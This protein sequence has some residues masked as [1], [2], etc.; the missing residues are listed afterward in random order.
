MKNI[1][2]LLFLLF[3]F[4]LSG[5]DLLTSRK[6]S[7]KTYIFKISNQE[8]EE[9]YKG[10]RTAFEI[11]EKYYHTLVDSFFTDSTYKKQ[12]PYGHYLDAHTSGNELITNIFTVSPFEVFVLN[13]QTDLM[14]QVRD[15][16]GNY[17]ENAEVELDSRAIKFNQETQSYRIGKSNQDGW[18]KVEMDG[19]IIFQQLNKQYKNSRAK[20]IYSK[21][22]YSRPIRWIWRPVRF[23]VGLPIDGV[24]SIIKGRTVG[25]IYRAK[26][27]PR[28]T[29]DLAIDAYEK[30]ACIFDDDYCNGNKNKYEDIYFATN[31]PKYFLK[32]TVFFK[33]FIVKSR[34]EKPIDKILEVSIGNSS[35]NEIKL[36]KIQP[37]YDGAYS[38]DFVLSDSLKLQLDRSYPIYLKDKKRNTIAYTYIKVEDYELGKTEF[39]FRVADNQQFA[40]DTFKIFAKGTDENDLQLPDAKIELTLLT[41]SISEYFPTQIFIPD[42]LWNHSQALKADGE[43]EIVL[44]DS[45][46]PNAEFTY[47]IIAEMRTSDNERI[48]KKETISYFQSKQE[49]ELELVGD[50][51]K[52]DYFKN[53]EV[54]QIAGTVEIFDGFSNS[55]RKQNV[56]FPAILPLNHYAS[57]LLVVAE[58]GFQQW[59]DLGN[60]SS[61]LQCFANRTADTVNIQVQNPH[62][63]PFVYQIYKQSN[64]IEKGNGL[65]LNWKEATSSKKNYYV[66]IQYLWAGKVKELN[67]EVGLKDKQLKISVEQPSLVVPGQ[68]VEL[69]VSVKDHKGKPVEDVDLLAYSLTSKFDYSAPNLPYLGKSRKAR[70]AFNKFS[71]DKKYREMD[72]RN[73]ELNYSK[74]NPLANLDSLEYYQLTY[75]KNNYYQVNFPSPDSLTQFAPFVVKGGEIQSIHSIEVDNLPIYFRWTISKNQPFSFLVDS[76]FHQVKLRT[77]THE[78][79]LDSVYFGVGE[80]QI[81]SV[82]VE[83]EAFSEKGKQLTKFITPEKY[84]QKTGFKS[85]LR[86]RLIYSQGRKSYPTDSENKKWNLYTAGYRNPHYSHFSAI[87]QGNRFFP[88]TGYS[89]LIGPLVRD[90]VH[91]SLLDSF[92]TSFVHE[93]NFQYEFYP[94]ILKMRTLNDDSFSYSLN[95]QKWSGSFSDLALTEN[96]F[97]E[98]WE[99]Y[100]LRMRRSSRFFSNP[101]YTKAGFGSLKIKYLKENVV[102]PLNIVMMKLDDADFLRVYN[103]VSTTFNQL[104][105]GNYKLIFLL[106]DN[107]YYSKDSIKIGV[108]GKNF[109]TISAPDSLSETPLGTEMLEMINLYLKTSETWS[110]GDLSNENLKRNLQIAYFAEN[111]NFN[112]DSP[113]ITGTVKD[114]TGEGLPGTTITIK[115]T[116]YGTVSDMDGNYSIR[117]NYGDILRFSFAGM[118]PTE[119]LIISQREIDVVLSSSAM[120]EEVVVVSYGMRKTGSVDRSISSMHLEEMRE[121]SIINSL[122]GKISGIE[123]EDGSLSFG[124]SPKILIRGNSTI[125]GEN[126][127]LYVIDGV[128]Y[129]GDLTQIRIAGKEVSP[130]MI[131]SMQVL[132]GAAAT[133]LYGA[134]G[135]NG[136]IL[137]TSKGNILRTE[138]ARI[139]G[140]EN[141]I[142]KDIEQAS[143]GSS[144][145]SNFSDYAFWK[146]NLRTNSEG[147]AQFKVKFPDDITK[148]ETFVLGVNGNRQ[149]GQAQGEIKSFKPL[150]AQLALPRFLLVGD[151]AFAIGKTLN[152]SADSVEVKQTFAVNDKNIWQ[153]NVRLERSVID[154]LLLT[155]STT[156]SLS[157]KYTME[158]VATNGKGYLDGELRKIPV[159]PVGFERA[160]GD[161]FTLDSDTSFTIQPETKTKKL[162][163]RAETDQLEVALAEVARLRKYKYYCNEQLASK[164]KGLLVEQRIAQFLGKEKDRK[165]EIEKI[166]EKLEK[167]QKTNGTWGWWENSSSSYWISTHVVQAFLQAEIAGFPTKMNKQALIDGLVWQLE[168]RSGYDKLHKLQILEMLDAKVDYKKHLA[169]LDTT[170]TGMLQKYQIL[171]LKQKLKLPYQTDSLKAEMRSTL[172]GNLYWSEREDDFKYYWNVYDNPVFTT[173]QAYKVLRNDSVDSGTLTKIRQ[174][175][176]ENRTNGYW[177]NTYESAQILETIVPDWLEKGENMKDLEKAKVSL[178]GLLSEDISQFPYEIELDL[179]SL[180]QASSSK[181]QPLEIT[182]TGDFPVYF[183]AYERIWETETD[184]TNS[185][186]FV[187]SSYF[188]ESPSSQ[189][190]QNLKLEAGEK[191][192]LT[193]KVVVKKT[194]DY[195]MVEIP[196]PASCSYVSKNKGSYLEAHREYARNKVSI[197]CETLKAG[198]YEFKVEL[199]P[200]YSGSYTLNPATAEQMYFPVF[201][202]NE[203]LKRVG[204]E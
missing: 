79:R 112:T 92:Q 193:A 175:F 199:L 126:N 111:Q 17:V 138:I 122:E 74:W 143:K 192:T 134:R 35:N 204:V 56:N 15:S 165:K 137:I 61:G 86:P 83:R 148:W 43:T 27:L 67:Y 136:V 130:D 184:T 2:L 133:A 177:R 87:K 22:I 57:R 124:A 81:F 4:S 44:P 152:Y 163:I 153:K 164:L 59:L 116:T 41:K 7:L 6:T 178:K 20:R 96:K 42:T 58:N 36:G 29:K 140:E 179:D 132:K 40:N 46:F 8:A 183:T 95:Q 145:R 108:D 159:F 77:S 203:E 144:L 102:L 117:A 129:T 196:I 88:L 90:S 101:N 18:L 127:P 156:D 50:S 39:K 70:K 182:K 78:V 161:F 181:I 89:G 3:T 162:I 32:D 10:K 160:V 93:T 25:S 71:L 187:V 84:I 139:I 166:I 94:N 173:L 24:R 19:L 55:M 14:I 26:T 135:A 169:H 100:V 172:F 38:F 54:S 155:T 198:T 151:S 197:F 63:I 105:K 109:L 189:S 60:Q 176:M 115:G 170:E 75:P 167:R 103:G 28:R 119:R 73:I 150:M 186:H 45:I 180:K 98:N 16:L 13:N 121:F 123:I 120:L 91:F 66:A 171:E 23:W 147:K 146:P 191:I 68:E 131:E 30:V 149:T 69:A 11:S 125:S 128:P 48:E 110:R 31:K 114:D 51:L 82:D 76:G 107:S 80:K 142:F 72:L 12:L 5:Q 85:G 200:R 194:A 21:V 104:E 195:V 97:Q 62:K 1:Y 33:T 113:V 9:I 37:K 99:E 201:Y 158:K 168:N 202:G 190:N 154:T 141:P 47:E 49:F 185:E 53:G 34:N 118:S 174:F 64:L 65:A 157:V 106:P 52:I 188:G